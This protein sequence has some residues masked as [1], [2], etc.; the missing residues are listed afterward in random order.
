MAIASNVSCL[1]SLLGNKLYKD[2]F[3]NE[4]S[5]AVDNMDGT[6]GGDASSACAHA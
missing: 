6:S 1:F 5:G 4:Q 3:K 2:Y